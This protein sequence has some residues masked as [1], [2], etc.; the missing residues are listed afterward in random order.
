MRTENTKT[1]FDYQLP[2]NKNAFTEISIKFKF[3]RKL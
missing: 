1:A 2:T 3:Q